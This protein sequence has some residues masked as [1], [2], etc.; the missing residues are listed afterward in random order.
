[1]IVWGEVFNRKQI[2]QVEDH[3]VVPICPVSSID[4]VRRRVNKNTVL[5]VISD[6]LPRSKNDYI[7][8]LESLND[9]YFAVNATEFSENFG[10]MVIDS[11]E[12]M[13]RN[14]EPTTGLCRSIV[15]NFPNLPIIVLRHQDIPLQFPKQV[16]EVALQPNKDWVQQQLLPRILEKIK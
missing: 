7:R 14:L 8:Y 13:R 12:S 2:S 9:L 16:T 1:M 10:Q 4:E 3:L 15:D 11:R 6:L 5:A